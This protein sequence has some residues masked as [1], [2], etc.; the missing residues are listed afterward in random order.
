VLRSLKKFN[1]PLPF[2][3]HPYTYMPSLAWSHRKI[4]VPDKRTALTQLLLVY[5]RNGSGINSSLAAFYTYR[6]LLYLRMLKEI[7]GT[8]KKI[9]LD[10]DA[11]SPTRDKLCGMYIHS[12]AELRE[13]SAR[14]KRI[15]VALLKLGIISLKKVSPGMGSS[16]HYAG[17][18][19]FSRIPKPLHLREDGMLHFTKNI[20]VADG[21][22]FRF[23]PAKGFAFSLMANAHRTAEHA[24]KNNE[25]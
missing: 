23:A 18:L 19:P 8:E 25:T 10:M 9:W 12:E 24:L 17:T 5:D 21:S 3:C 20:F 15:M 11:E 16:I 1:Y 7:Y 6:S 14:E 4:I 22:G 2:L 13:I